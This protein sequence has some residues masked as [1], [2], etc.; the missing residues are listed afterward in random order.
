M[1]VTGVIMPLS[2]DGSESFLPR[3]ERARGVIQFFPFFC[4][5][6]IAEE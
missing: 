3:L 2:A 1:V 5:A 4:H 6:T